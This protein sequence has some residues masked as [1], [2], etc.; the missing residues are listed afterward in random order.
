MFETQVNR[1]DLKYNTSF[2][3]H[4]DSRKIVNRKIVIYSS[5]ARYNIQSESQFG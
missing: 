4:T 2:L 3:N 5:F 1:M